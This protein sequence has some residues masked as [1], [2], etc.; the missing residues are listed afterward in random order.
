MRARGRGLK[1]VGEILRFVRYQSFAE[2]HDAHRIRWYVVIAKCEFSH[3]EIAA[4]NN[5]PDGKA[6]L[7]GLHESALLDVVPT[8]DLLARLR[9]IKHGI[10]AVDV[11]LDIEIAGIRS[12]PVTLQCKPHRSIIH[13]NPPT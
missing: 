10:L 3:P 12:I 1:S 4:S 2:F 6:L 8:A 7:I 13:V 11:V 9:I 5:S